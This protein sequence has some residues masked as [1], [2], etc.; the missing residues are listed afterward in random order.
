MHIN[1]SE[2]RVKYLDWNGLRLPVLFIPPPPDG[3]DE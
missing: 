1:E 3:T 2:I